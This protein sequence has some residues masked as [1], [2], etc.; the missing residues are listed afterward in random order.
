MI[1]V[2]IAT[3]LLWLVGGTAYNH[4]ATG[5]GWPTVGFSELFAAMIL[6]YCLAFWLG[7]LRSAWGS[8]P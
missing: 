5:M 7:V 1:P 2:V 6:S 4:L 8:Q 3:A